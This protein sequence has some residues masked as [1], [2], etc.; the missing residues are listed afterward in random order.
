MR[1]LLAPAFA[2]LFL[3]SPAMA[4]QPLPHDIDFKV[5]RDGD[6][7]GHHR[8]T[9]ARQGDDVIADVDIELSVSFAGI[10]M[11][12]YHHASRETWADGKLIGIISNT[13][14]DG[15]EE[16]LNLSRKGDAL[17][18]DGTKYQGVAPGALVP[19]SYWF[20]ST[21]EQTQI[22]DSQNGRIFPC[23]IQKIGR[24]TVEAGGMMIP[25]T[26]YT[27]S[28]QLTMNLWYDDNGEWVK[29]SFESDGS[30]IDYVLQP[31][32]QRAAAN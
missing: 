31:R 7:I 21:I 19:T 15:D 14:N 2:L 32:Q 28:E 24:E 3:A 4:E 18:I 12:Y 16:K 25:A 20:P 13:D 5:Y 26:R 29:T 11:F 9:F 8:V 10:R 22:I 6:E 23:A 17:Q 30:L 27:L 1:A